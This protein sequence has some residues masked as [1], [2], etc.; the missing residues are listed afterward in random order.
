LLEQHPS[1]RQALNKA[2]CATCCNYLYSLEL[3]MMGI[4]VPETC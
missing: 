2:L 3:L 4:M 1:T